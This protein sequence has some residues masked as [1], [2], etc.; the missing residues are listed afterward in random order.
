VRLPS[1]DRSAAVGC[2][3]DRTGRTR[4]LRR[5]AET[6]E[7]ASRIGFRGSPTVLV[8]GHDPFVTG[9]EPTGLA[10]RLYTTPEGLRGSPTREQLR[11]ALSSRR[12][13]STP[14]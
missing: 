9:D 14:P 12:S 7:A 2:L 6:P 11:D 4:Q 8:D 5:D 1:T 13:S 10:C 3:G